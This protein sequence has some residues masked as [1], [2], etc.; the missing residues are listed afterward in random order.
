MQETRLLLRIP[1][2]NALPEILDYFVVLR[3]AAVV[4]VFLPVIH[5]NICDTTDKQF[6]FAFVENVNKIRGDELVETGDERLELLFDTLLNTPFGNK[7]DI[8]SKI[9]ERLEW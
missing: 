8:V 2:A 7:S 4:G 6:K 3:V 5:I 9:S 1:A